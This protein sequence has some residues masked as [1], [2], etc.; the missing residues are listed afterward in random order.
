MDW[1]LRG[2]EE[3]DIGHLQMHGNGQAAVH[4]LVS[5]AGRRDC[6]RTIV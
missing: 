2:Q 4:D 6:E 5:W 1:Q 3:H